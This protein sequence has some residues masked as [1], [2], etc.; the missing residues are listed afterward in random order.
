MRADQ[1]AM[2]LTPAAYRYAQADAVAPPNALYGPTG[3]DI[4]SA[5]GTPT[6]GDLYAFPFY[7]GF[8]GAI[9]QVAFN[10]S[11]AGGAGSVARAGI[12][13]S[14]ASGF[15]LLPRNLL[16]DG[17]EY[18]CTGATA[19][20]TTL[21]PKI[22]LNEGQMYWFAFMCGVAAPTVTTFTSGWHIFGRSATFAGQ[23]GW[24]KVGFGYG[25]LPAQWPAGTPGIC[26]SAAP[27]V[28]VRFATYNRMKR[29]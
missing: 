9:D 28:L 11:V 22:A 2:D 14:D 15:S 17:G 12:Y 19:K 8:G 7:A 4:V 3:A 10:V 5:T 27:L 13:D 25:P 20:I 24:Q 6:V 1:F 18:D 26:T 16:V 23:F 21:S 29:P